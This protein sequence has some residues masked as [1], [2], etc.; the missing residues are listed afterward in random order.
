MTMLVK[1]ENYYR[2]CGILSTDFRCKHLAQCQGCMPP[3]PA[4]AKLPEDAENTFTEA[5][6]AFVGEHYRECVP[7]LLFVSLD[8]GSALTSKDSEYNYISAESRLPEGVRQGEMDRA[9]RISHG[10]AKSS[11]RLRETNKLAA[12]ILGRPTAE[13]MRFYAHTNAAKCNM[14]KPKRA[15]ANILLFQNCRG[16][17]RG[18]IDILGPDVIIT[19]GEEAKWGMSHAFGESSEFG[20]EQTISMPCGKQAIWFPIYSPSNYGRFYALLD[21]KWGP[22]REGLAKRIRDFISNRDS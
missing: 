17:L 9:Q 1:L 18:E 10:K 20:G 8:P 12:L 6:A 13:V 22:N 2:E 16:Y 4:D 15:E 21:D 19:L 14:N 11:P 7:R 3:T 5:K